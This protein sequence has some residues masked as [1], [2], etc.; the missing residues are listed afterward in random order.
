MATEEEMKHFIELATL[1]G[2]SFESLS[3]G[4]NLDPHDNYRSMISGR[5]FGDVYS[6]YVKANAMISMD[7]DVLEKFEYSITHVKVA[8]LAYDMGLTADDVKEYLT[9]IHHS[10]IK[11][12]IEKYKSVL[13][14]SMEKAYVDSHIDSILSNM[15]DFRSGDFT[16]DI[17]GVACSIDIRTEHLNF[18]DDGD[19]LIYPPEIVPIR[20]TMTWAD[21]I[22]GRKKTCQKAISV[23]KIPK[24]FSDI[25]NFCQDT[26]HDSHAMRSI[27]S[28]VVAYNLLTNKLFKLLT[29]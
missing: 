22:T 1:S 5:D 2:M 23:D 25:Q 9:K 4:G 21:K 14:N 12:R 8:K 3:K 20:F 17:D 10:K 24:W 16:I 27:M 13:D 6:D 26:F 28:Y 7:T 29:R 15:T 19:E 18:Y 11:E